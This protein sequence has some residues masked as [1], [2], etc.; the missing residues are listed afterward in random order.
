MCIPRP[1]F[2]YI[3]LLRLSPTSAQKSPAAG[4]IAPAAGLFCALVGES[5]SRLMYEKQ[6]LGM[7]MGILRQSIRRALQALLQSGIIPSIASPDSWRSQKLGGSLKSGLPAKAGSSYKT[8]GP[9]QAGASRDTLM[10]EA[11]GLARWG[12]PQND[13]RL[14]VA[15]P[16][17]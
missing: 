11:G 17:V 16:P 3:S 7:H 4:A 13:I 12:V 6:G 1:C 9:H 14:N 8:S 15:E 5:R 10:P 2:S